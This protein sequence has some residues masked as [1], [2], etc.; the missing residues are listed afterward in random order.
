MINKIHYEIPSNLLEFLESLKEQNSF[1]LYDILMTS[2]QDGQ[3]FGP[4][5][6]HFE[7]EVRLFLEGKGRFWF[8]LPTGEIIH[9]DMNKGDWINIPAGISHWYEFID[10]EV[11]V[12]R[13]FTGLEGWFADYSRSAA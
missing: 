8:E 5:H 3:K 10:S 13:F 9:Q 2:Q 6:T 12:A 4:K 1:K 7:D 11:T